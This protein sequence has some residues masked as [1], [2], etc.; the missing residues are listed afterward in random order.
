MYT[1]GST[2]LPKGTLNTHLGFVN[3]VLS[4][5]R[6]LGMSSEDRV[7]QFSSPSFDVS[8]FEICLAFFNGATLVVPERKELSVLPSFIMGK[9]VSV[10]ML[11][12]MVIGSLD[13]GTLSHVRALMTGGEEARPQDM[14]RLSG[15]T[16]LFNIYGTTEA[17]VW[18]TIHPVGRWEDPTRRVP[19]GRPFDNVFACILDADRR[20]VPTGGVGEL[21][22]GG[23][24]LPS[25]Y[26]RKPELSAERFIP[27]P[28]H[29]GQMLYRTG[30][31]ARWD[32]EG[33]LCFLGRMDGQVKVNGHRVEPA[34][35]VASLE[36]VDGIARAAVI[37]RPGQ[38][39]E[40]GLVA[41]LVMEEGRVLDE[42]GLRAELSQRLPG[43]MLPVR[44]LTVD[45]IP[46]NPNGKVD[47]PLLLDWD[48]K[49]LEERAQRVRSGVL[50]KPDTPTERRLAAIW[51][52]ILGIE[53]I[54]ADDSFFSLGGNSLQLIRLMDRIASGWSLAVDPSGIFIHPALR[55]MAR[56]LDDRSAS[57]RIEGEGNPFLPVEAWDTGSGR[58]LFAMVGGAGSISEFTKYHRIGSFL[59]EAWRVHILPDPDASHGRFPKMGPAQLA[60]RYAEVV[61]PVAKREKV[62]LLGDCIGGIDA[63][64]LACALQSS[65][66]PNIGLILM[67]VSAPVLKREVPALS[68]SAID[69]YHL[70][71]ERQDAIREAMHD[72]MLPLVGMRSA[73]LLF[74]PV[75]GSRRQAFRMAVAL[76]LFNP[77][78]YLAA[79]PESGPTH[80]DAFRHYME[81]GWKDG[82]M[83]ASGFNPHRY[84]KIV[85]G[86]RPGNDE[87]VLHALIFGMRVRYVRRK[88]LESVR[89]PRLHSDLMAARTMLRREMFSP[90]VFRG[91]L[92]LVMSGRVFYRG[93]DLG[94][95]R[96]VEGKVHLHRAEG[97]HRTYLKE[98]LDATASILKQILSLG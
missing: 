14:G 92:H 47:R 62:W 80:Y 52:Q 24:G 23:P 63:F 11:T 86:F 95:S 53:T 61:L 29:P 32:D 8:V 9:R 38:G 79:F 70:L 22:V 15:I 17:C 69:L 77:I 66:V 67:D 42:T 88:V 74:H 1:S 71:P 78:E 16:S 68:S 41:F 5:S 27:D 58:H 97:D 60:D 2:G 84:R 76:G 56:L 64:A 33:R 50:P 34:E 98:E 10:A 45:D 57:I 40:S 54:H 49:G 83:P 96:H 37:H 21:C 85:D 7:A 44:C 25:G 30:D 3:T 90:G 51:S 35:V 93:T 20:L 28:F 13:A 19:L 91:D 65:G 87:P 82:A 36:A 73:G 6:A 75:P 89:R 43:H 94:W 81:K 26:H 18:S 4:V 46:L 48:D 12:P 31:L 39:P 55:A 72:M 59:G